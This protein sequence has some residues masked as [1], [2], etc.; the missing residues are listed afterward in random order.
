MQQGIT[1][2]PLNECFHKQCL[3]SSS[4]RLHCE[5]KGEHTNIS[6]HEREQTSAEES[7]TDKRENISTFIF[8]LLIIWKLHVGITL[9]LHSLLYMLIARSSSIIKRKY[10]SQQEVQPVNWDGMR[11]GWTSKWFFLCESRT[12]SSL[13]CCT[14]CTHSDVISALESYYY[15]NS[16]TKLQHNQW[17]MF[18][19]Y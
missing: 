5:I 3:H 18:K 17:L 2:V 4:H 14:C 19:S 12:T 9:L 15:C 7:Q 1:P 8:L 13:L 6:I 16:D 11:Q 10:K